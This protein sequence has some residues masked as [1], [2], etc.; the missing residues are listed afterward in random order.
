M[1]VF[2]SYLEYTTQAL[3]VL[4]VTLDLEVSRIF[5]YITLFESHNESLI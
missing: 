3:Q 2:I 5:I 4:T 1:Y